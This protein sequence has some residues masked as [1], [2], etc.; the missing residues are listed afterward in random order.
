MPGSRRIAFR[1]SPRIDSVPAT[2]SFARRYGVRGTSSTTFLLI[3]GNTV[4]NTS[5][6]VSTQPPTVTCGLGV[7]TS[8]RAMKQP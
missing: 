8:Q 3:S 6:S 4:R 1:M 2:I 5:G 7:A